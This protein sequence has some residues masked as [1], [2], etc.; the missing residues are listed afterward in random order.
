MASGSPIGQPSG[1]PAKTTSSAGKLPWMS[2]IR[3]QCF[4]MSGS[5]GSRPRRHQPQRARQPDASWSLILIEETFES[6]TRGFQDFLRL[7]L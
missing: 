3:I 4:S 5:L 2:A 1:R 6:L 7:T